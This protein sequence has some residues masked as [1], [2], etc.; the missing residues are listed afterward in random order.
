MQYLNIN[1]SKKLFK[2]SKLNF[3]I[4]LNIKKNNFFQK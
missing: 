4:E 1:K 3:N 2:Y